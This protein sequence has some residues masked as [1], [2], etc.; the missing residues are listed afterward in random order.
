M[1]EGSVRVLLVEDDEDDYLLTRDLLAELPAG[2]YQLDRV[3]DLPSALAALEQSAH[4][5]YLVDYRLGAHTGLEFVEEAIRRGTKAPMIMLTAQREREVD[6][7]AMQAGAVDFLV[8]DRLDAATIDRSIRYALQQKRHE[9]EIE[10]ANQQLEARVAERTAELEAVNQTLQIEIA[11]RKRAEE[12]LRRADRRKD[13]FLA[14]LAHELRN[15]LSPLLV[16]TQLIGLEPANTRQIREL[17]G[18]MSRQL[19]QLIRLIDDLLDVSRI[20]SGKLRLRREPVALGEAIATALDV[21]KPLIAAYRHQLLVTLPPQPLIVDG[22]KVRLTQIVGNLLINAAKYTPAGGR[23]ELSARAEEAQAI[24]SVRDNGMGIPPEMQSQI[25]NLF[26][27]VDNS[28]R[29]SQSG[30]GIGLTLAK[31]LVEMHGGTI[32]V[33]SDGAGRGSEFLIRLP[34][35]DSQTLPAVSAAADQTSLAPPAT[36]R[37]LIV[38]DNQS[39]SYLLSR[40]LAKLGQQV[41]VESSA[42]AALTAVPEFLPDIVISD[43]AMPELSGYQLAAKIRAL[44]DIRQPVLVALTGYGQ[45]SDRQEALAAGFDRHLTKPIGLPELERLLGEQPSREAE[46]PPSPPSPSGSGS[47]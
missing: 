20:S 13:E 1:P 24:V 5:V 45:E 36:F 47:G 7:L 28:K 37:I 9:E 12:A 41:R 21:S 38:D 15:P 23:I 22:D 19:E 43:I 27:Q 42:A 46:A 16:A 2:A 8:K 35:A 14:T 30:L 39:A 3:A 4:D 18:V 40:L 44:P 17:A 26:T 25:F 10:R 32:E 6:L 34:L 29:R 33:A 31:T 11:E